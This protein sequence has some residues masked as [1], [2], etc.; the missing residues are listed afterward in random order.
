MKKKKKVGNIN[1]IPSY[2]YLIWRGGGLYEH[3][4]VRWEHFLKTNQTL[5]KTY[6]FENVTHYK[7]WYMC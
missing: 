3:P 4:Y 7:H 1:L 2:I 6:Y 5:H